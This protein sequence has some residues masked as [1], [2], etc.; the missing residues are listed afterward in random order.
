MKSSFPNVALIG[1][2]LHI[3]IT[4]L[5]ASIFENSH[6]KSQDAKPT[7][8]AKDIFFKRQEKALNLYKPKLAWYNIRI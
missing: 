7:K 2:S 5:S 6:E 8:D 3:H 1:N 4:L